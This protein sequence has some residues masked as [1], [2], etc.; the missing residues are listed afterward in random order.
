[1]ANLTWDL[2]IGGDSTGRFS[3]A[4]AGSFST[5]TPILGPVDWT[6]VALSYDPDEQTFEGYQNFLGQTFRFGFG[7]SGL[8]FN[9]VICLPGQGPSEDC[10][11]GLF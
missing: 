2:S 10:G 7:P 8:T 9:H 1:L 3:A 11:P 6:T 4:Y 5:N